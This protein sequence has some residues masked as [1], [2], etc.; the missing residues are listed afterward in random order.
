MPK[1]S[2]G[3]SKV[4]RH[5]DPAPRGIDTPVEPREAAVLSTS[6]YAA[7]SDIAWL[8]ASARACRRNAL[9]MRLRRV[10]LTSR[11]LRGSDKNFREVSCCQ[12]WVS[13]CAVTR[14]ASPVEQVC[15]AVQKC[16]QLASSSGVVDATC[17]DRSADVH[18]QGIPHLTVDLALRYQ[19]AVQLCQLL[20]PA[21]IM[22]PVTL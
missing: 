4:W 15:F 3:G 6:L 20:K 13:Q 1:L 22:P 11:P 19:P 7:L 17:S 5:Q 8:V 21:E 16:D 14:A 9:Q 10:G 2:S 12:S 18:Q